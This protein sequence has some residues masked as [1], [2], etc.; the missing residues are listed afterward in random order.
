[1]RGLSP[2]SRGLCFDAVASSHR[3]FS[4]GSLTAVAIA[5]TTGALIGFGHRLG[6]AGLP[7]AAIAASL[8]H[9]TTTTTDGELVAA[10]FAAHAVIIS[11]WVLVFA[12]LVRVR[13]WRMPVAA[14]VIVALAHVLSWLFA[15]WTGNGLSSVLPLGDRIV[16]AIVF[17]GALVV[18]IRLAFLFDGERR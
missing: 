10:G 15:L 5:A 16:F 6:G 7:F 11:A 9:R 14:I 1:M 18:G 8:L 17:A 13:G 2:G 3:S 12:W 4:I